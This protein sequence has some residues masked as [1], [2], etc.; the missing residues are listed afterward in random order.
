MQLDLIQLNLNIKQKGKTNKLY[1]NQQGYI[2]IIIIR[3]KSKEALL[4][5][6]DDD[7]VKVRLILSFYVNVQKKIGPIW[8]RIFYI[9]NFNKQSF[10]HRINF[11]RTVILIIKLLYQDNQENLNQLSCEKTTVEDK[12]I[13]TKQQN[14]NNNKNGYR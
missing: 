7:I 13:S 4:V 10:R 11:N 9:S 6:F 8:H 1:K 14:S 2:H 12:F 5:K 3:A